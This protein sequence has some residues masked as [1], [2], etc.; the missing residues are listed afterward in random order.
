[1]MFGWL[2]VGHNR[3]KCKLQSDR[4]PCC[5]AQDETFKY[6]LQCKH[7]SLQNA[8]AC[9]YVAL[10]TA[11]NKLNLPPYFTTII[12]SMMKIT[13]ENADPPKVDEM[14]PMSTAIESQQEIGFYNMILGFY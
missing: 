13:L 11:F 5:G 2:T 8:R 4:C 3:H 9:A 1:M 7:E 10:K 6:L 12:I 14:S